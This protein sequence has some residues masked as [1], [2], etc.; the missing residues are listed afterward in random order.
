[1]L[2]KRF[3]KEAKIVYFFHRIISHPSKIFRPV[4]VLQLTATKQGTAGLR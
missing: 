1:M 4:P 2:Q 3:V